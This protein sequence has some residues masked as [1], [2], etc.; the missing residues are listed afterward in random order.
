[1]VVFGSDIGPDTDAAGR[2]AHQRGS[3]SVKGK[4][5][6]Y[7]SRDSGIVPGENLVSLNPRNRKGK[8]VYVDRRLTEDCKERSRRTCAVRKTGT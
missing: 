5:P 3:K 2:E 4:T 1:M 6:T 8:G 7:F